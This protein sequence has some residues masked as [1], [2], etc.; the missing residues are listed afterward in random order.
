M[1]VSRKT[2]KNKQREFKIVINL[3]GFYIWFLIGFMT[4]LVLAIYKFDS[5]GIQ[6][7]LIA[8]ALSVLLVHWF[9]KSANSLLQETGSFAIPGVYELRQKYLLH[10]NRIEKMWLILAIWALIFVAL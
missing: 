10:V 8:P 3:V 9:H 7:K 6:Y 1:S 5:L 2:L 4:P